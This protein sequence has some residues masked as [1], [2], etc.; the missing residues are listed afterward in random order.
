MNDQ[1]RDYGLWGV[2]GEGSGQIAGS[3]SGTVWTPGPAPEPG[4]VEHPPP[5]QERERDAE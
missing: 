3:N 1:E 2:I 5:G 4:E